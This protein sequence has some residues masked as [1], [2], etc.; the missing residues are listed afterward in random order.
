MQKRGDRW[1]IVQFHV[2]DPDPAGRRAAALASA[3]RRNPFGNSG[4]RGRGRRH[5][6]AAACSA[7][8]S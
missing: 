2:T 1:M 7:Q 4:S 5:V 6:R 3:A 8:R